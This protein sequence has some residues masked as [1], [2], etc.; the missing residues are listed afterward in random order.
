MLP[1]RGGS[2]DGRVSARPCI[3]REVELQASS[4]IEL[5]GHPRL[6]EAI[7]ETFV[8][9]LVARTGERE[10]NRR[11]SAERGHPRIGASLKVGGERGASLVGTT[12]QRIGRGE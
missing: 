10:R 2:R 11:Q 1:P 5:F 3:S 12:Q 4:D 6:A 9:L 7:I 8:L